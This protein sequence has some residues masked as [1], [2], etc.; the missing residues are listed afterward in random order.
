MNEGSKRCQKI[1]NKSSSKRP[2]LTLKL[3]D[4]AKAFRIELQETKLL[5]SNG[6]LTTV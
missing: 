1:T 4:T 5:I 3:E 2:P 6:Q